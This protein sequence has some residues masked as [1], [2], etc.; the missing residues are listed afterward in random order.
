MKL[1]SLNSMTFNYQ[2]N[3]QAKNNN[4]NYLNTVAKDSV[5]F[6]HAEED[7]KVG[8]Y[9]GLHAR[10]ASKIT[11]LNKFLND[12]SPSNLTI[13]FPARKIVLE[14]PNALDLLGLDGQKGSTLKITVDSGDDAVDKRAVE[15]YKEI[16]TNEEMEE[17]T[18]DETARWVADQAENI[19]FGDD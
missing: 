1:N 15:A 7:V 9:S 8:L 11:M 14:N 2:N 4:V 6:G 10:P 16:L 5:S 12:I 17:Y 18:K 19:L 13:S 3:Y